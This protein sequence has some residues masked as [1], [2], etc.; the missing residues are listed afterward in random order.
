MPRYLLGYSAF[1]CHDTI[2]E[3]GYDPDALEMIRECVKESRA[4]PINRARR[5]NKLT[6]VLLPLLDRFEI[7]YH[8]EYDR[9]WMS[10]ADARYPPRMYNKAFADQHRV[11]ETVHVVLYSDDDAFFVRLHSGLLP[12]PA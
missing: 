4:N 12:E 8:F 3:R 5:Y 9:I 1:V 7:L 6:T 10:N 11:V 2:R